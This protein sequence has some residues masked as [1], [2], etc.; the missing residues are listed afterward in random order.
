MSQLIF[1][2]KHHHDAQICEAVG[3]GVKTIEILFSRAELFQVI[4]REFLIVV[5][6]KIQH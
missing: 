1:I 4:S 5:A 2:F 3:E 6:H